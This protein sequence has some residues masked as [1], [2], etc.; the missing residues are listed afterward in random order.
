M[1]DQDDMKP[2][3]K[4]VLESQDHFRQKAAE[5][6]RKREK[7]AVQSDL[8]IVGEDDKEESIEGIAAQDV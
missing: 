3:K 6:K 7:K 8:T 1:C 2:E 5:H 4:K